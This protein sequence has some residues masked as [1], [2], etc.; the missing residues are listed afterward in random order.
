MRPSEELGSRV[1]DDRS[2]LSRSSDNDFSMR[3]TQERTPETQ[4]AVED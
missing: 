1:L 2:N 3:V 4:I